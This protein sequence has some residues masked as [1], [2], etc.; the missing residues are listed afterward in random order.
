MHSTEATANFVIPQKNGIVESEIPSFLLSVPYY[1]STAIA[2]N[3]IMEDMARIYP[4]VCKNNAIKQFFEF[5]QYLSSNAF[6]QLLPSVP[7]LQDQVYVSNLG[8]IID[9][10]DEKVALLANFKSE[11]RRGEEIHGDRCLQSLGFRTICAPEYFEGEADLKKISANLYVGAHGMRTSLDALQW[12]ESTLNLSIIKCEITNPYLYHLDCVLCPIGEDEVL[13]ATSVVNKSTLKELERNANIID[14]PLD[15]ALASGTNCIRV[16][17][18][19]LCDNNSSLYLTQPELYRKEQA[20]IEY[21]EKIC[22][23]RGLSLKTFEMTEFIKSGAAL[24]C[25][26]MKLY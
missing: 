17:D 22:S 5:Y 18:S 6:V 20:K 2:N 14:V 19:L 25:L 10:G 15:I 9:Q 26:A 13:V 21:L 12:I 24:S 3:K 23:E 4:P 11:P 16:K 7:G 1:I 8:A